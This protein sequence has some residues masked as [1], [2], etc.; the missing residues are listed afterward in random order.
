[1]SNIFPYVSRSMMILSIIISTTSKEKKYLKNNR[2]FVQMTIK[3]SLMI[4]IIVIFLSKTVE[5]LRLSSISN[6]KFLCLA[7]LLLSEVILE[8][9]YL[10]VKLYCNY[11]QDY[12]SFLQCYDSEY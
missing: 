9:N 3:Q 7:H 12:N 8:I 1:M 6:S 4:L 2:I 5:V 11:P 10:A